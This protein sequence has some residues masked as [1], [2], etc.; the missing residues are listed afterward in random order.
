MLNI[1]HQAM[2]LLKIDEM[3][4]SLAVIRYFSIVERIKLR[5]LN[6][7]LFVVEH[8]YQLSNSLYHKVLDLVVFVFV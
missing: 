7:P 4:F 8:R 1:S 2:F 5:Q 3:L 6:A